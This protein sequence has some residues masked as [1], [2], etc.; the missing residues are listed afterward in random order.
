MPVPAT[1]PVVRLLEVDPELQAAIPAEDLELALRVGAVPATR[2]APGRWQPPEGTDGG[3]FAFI[4]AGGAMM[5]TLSI[6]DRESARILGP[7][8]IFDPQRSA[9]GL[10]TVDI[11]WEALQPTT[12]GALDERYLAM[13]RRW[14][15]LM[16]ALQRRL[17]D[18]A[19][20]T[21]IVAAIAHLPRV[22]MRVLALFWHLAERFGRMGAEGVVLPLRLTHAQLGMLVGAQRPTVTIALQTLR[23]GGDVERRGD[24]TW[25]LTDSSR[26][27]LRSA[28]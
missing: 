8:D 1:S 23:D 19:N 6:G 15:S 16:V 7:G 21:A 3:P 17:C 10:L 14:P 2:I 12:I 25:W 13:A 11:R 4:I 20:R 24:G 18:E 9:G 27:K 22:E 28:A 26:D 5:S